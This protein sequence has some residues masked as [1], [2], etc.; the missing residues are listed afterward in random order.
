MNKGLYSNVLYENNQ[1]SKIFKFSQKFFLR[2]CEKNEQLSPCGG[3]TTQET[4]AQGLLFKEENMQELIEKL[5]KRLENEKMTCE[6][7]KAEALIGMNGV[8]ASY[9]DGEK[10]AY[11]KAEIGRAHV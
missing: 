1:L 11:D 7:A 2:I 5:I 8:S 10:Q 9:Y 6:S 4:P 3:F